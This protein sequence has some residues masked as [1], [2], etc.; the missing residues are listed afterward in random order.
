MQSIDDGKKNKSPPKGH[1][2]WGKTNLSHTGEEDH[3][4]FAR[5]TCGEGKR[6]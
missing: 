2:Y 1:N 4:S 6:H 3:D 5:I